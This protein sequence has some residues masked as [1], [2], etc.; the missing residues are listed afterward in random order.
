MP[1][2]ELEALH[3]TV[4]PIPYKLKDCARIPAEIHTTPRISELIKL[5]ASKVSVSLQS[6]VRFLYSNKTYEALCGS[7]HERRELG[8]TYGQCL[9]ARD[10]HL[11]HCLTLDIHGFLR[12]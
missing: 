10:F 1:L 2:C 4:S 8:I 6:H 3:M 11:R 7:M 5:E 9:L 12:F